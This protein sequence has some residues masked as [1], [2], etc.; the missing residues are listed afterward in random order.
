MGSCRC[1]QGLRPVRE[2]VL[3]DQVTQPAPGTCPAH[4][5]TH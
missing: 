1:H 4:V 3:G 5:G 2:G